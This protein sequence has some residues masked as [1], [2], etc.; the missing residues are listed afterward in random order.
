MA[1]LKRR[2][3][4]ERIRATVGKRKRK[5]EGERRIEERQAGNAIFL[6]PL[7]EKKGRIA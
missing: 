2:K 1:I 4:G 5:V 3:E 7:L 6:S